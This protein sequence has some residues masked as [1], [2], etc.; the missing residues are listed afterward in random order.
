MIGHT[1]GKKGGL[2][3]GGSVEV[4][5]VVSGCRHNK[6]AVGKAGAAFLQ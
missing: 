3:D 2:F 1:R 6:E 4:V 5:L